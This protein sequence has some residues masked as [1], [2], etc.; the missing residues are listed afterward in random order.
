MPSATQDGLTINRSGQVPVRASLSARQAKAAGLMTSGTCGLT[1]IGSLASADLST[2]LASKLQAATQMLGSTLYK[3]TWKQWVTPSG[4]SRSRLRASAHRTSAIERTGWPTPTAN[5]GTGAGTEGRQGGMN[6][7]SAAML[8]GWPSPMASDG[9]GGKGPRKG[10]SITGRMPDGSKASMGLNA[11]AKLALTGWPTPQAID[12]NSGV[13][14]PRLKKDGN[15]DRMAEGSYRSDL[16][17]APYLIFSAPPYAEL[18]GWPTP[19][20]IDNNQVRGEAAAANAPQRGTTIGGAAR[21]AGWPTPLANEARL[22]YQNRSNGKKG[23]QESLTTVVV[24][25]IGEREHLP[26]HQPARLTASGEMLTGCS[27][28]MKSG[29]Q[30]DPAHSRWLMGLPPEWDDCAPTA[31]PSTRKRQKSS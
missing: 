17:D 14:A 7:Q 9:S 23:S 22:G 27:A 6:I 5:A 18:M 19:T 20:T 3:L 26:N 4:L 12:S 16:K 15:R 28:G 25:S 8:A 2:S 29:G 10:V 1:S 11:V 30:L 24:N 31:M 21:L 13:R